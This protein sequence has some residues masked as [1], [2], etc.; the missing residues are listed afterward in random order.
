MK[1]RRISKTRVRA[2]KMRQ[3][4]VNKNNTSI[5]I[6]NMKRIIKKAV[7]IKRRAM[8]IKDTI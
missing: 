4:K 1:M 6:K 3:A 8:I 2:Q 5:K 7:I